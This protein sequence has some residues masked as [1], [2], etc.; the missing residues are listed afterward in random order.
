MARTTRNASDRFR[1]QLK[2]ARLSVEFRRNL[3]LDVRTAQEEYPLLSRKY[4]NQIND[5][6]T[7]IPLG[8][9]ETRRLK[10]NVSRKTIRTLERLS[11]IG[12]DA[13][14]LLR[15][16]FRHEKTLMTKLCDHFKP[17]IGWSKLR[18]PFPT[19]RGERM[20]FTRWKNLP[21]RING[22][23]VGTHIVAPTR[24]GLELVNHQ[25]WL[26]YFFQHLNQVLGSTLHLTVPIRNHVMKTLS[27]I[28][29]LLDDCDKTRRSAWYM[30][31]RKV[32]FFW[33]RRFKQDLI[34]AQ[35][36]SGHGLRL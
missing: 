9:K 36:T 1:P 6:I 21:K 4:R 27:S 16:D 35:K 28:P 30:R 32:V 25:F 24:R 31:S 26:W 33:K 19:V 15:D 7:G 29:H 17:K 18:T 5:L 20:A 12:A 23:H 13:K 2:A 11:K 22:V 34:E 10:R 14:T 8:K 3:Y